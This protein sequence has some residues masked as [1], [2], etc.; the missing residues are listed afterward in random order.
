VTCTRRD[1]TRGFGGAERGGRPVFA[2][3]LSLLRTCAVRGVGTCFYRR[4]FTVAGLYC[5][6]R[7]QDCT[8]RR[9]RSDPPHNSEGVTP[10]RLVGTGAS[11]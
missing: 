4:S 9:E 1:L 2:A 6:V 8:R 5:T 3:R 7:L 10:H 11:L